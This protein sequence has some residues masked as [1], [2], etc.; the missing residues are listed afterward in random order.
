MQT[1]DEL[2]EVA[3]SMPGCKVL[4]SSGQPKLSHK[5]YRM[6]KD[7]RRFYDLAGGASL[8]PSADFGFHVAAPTELVPANPVLL[9]KEVYSKYR[10]DFAMSDSWYL[11][12][13]GTGP[14]EA[15]S[16]DLAA[17]RLGR[18]YDSFHEVH[19]TGDSLIIAQSFTEL[20]FRILDSRGK[21]LWWDGPRGFSYGRAFDDRAGKGVISYYF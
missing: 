20:L 14:E 11:I 6:P 17:D 1:I 4:P 16:I 15:I 8:F 3:A 9:P 2:V 12:C 7:L 19:G 5:N 21:K 10:A 13:R 18:C